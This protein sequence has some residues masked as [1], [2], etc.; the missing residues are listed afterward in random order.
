[1]KN[2]RKENYEKKGDG[3]HKAEVRKERYVQRRGKKE[4]KEKR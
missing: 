4:K 3:D 2:K 1:M